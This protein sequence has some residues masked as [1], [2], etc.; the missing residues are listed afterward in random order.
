VRARS[1]SPVIP[2]CG[3]RNRWPGPGFTRVCTCTRAALRL[4]VRRRRRTR[5]RLDKRKFVV[6]RSRC[7]SRSSTFWLPSLL[8]FQISQ[9]L[10]RSRRNMLKWTRVPFPTS[11]WKVVEPTWLAGHPRILVIF[12][13]RVRGQYLECATRWNEKE[14]ARDETRCFS[15]SVFRQGRS[16]A[17]SGSSYK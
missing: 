17:T 2:T 14:E 15:T 5:R 8:V 7:V 3:R 16:R 13:I 1:R 6:A 11:A 4:R 10:V 9:I 12:A